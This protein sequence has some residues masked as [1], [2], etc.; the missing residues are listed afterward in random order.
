MSI[1]SLWQLDSNPFF[2]D[3]K[4]SGG[5]Y[6]NSYRDFIKRSKLDLSLKN[7]V[8][9][10]AFNFIPSYSSTVEIMF[11]SHIFNYE[12]LYTS[13]IHKKL[14]SID[15]TFNLSFDVRNDLDAESIK[16]YIE[17][18]AGEEPFPLQFAD[19]LGLDQQNAYKSLFSLPPYMVQ[20]FTCISVNHDESY[21]NQN[22][23]SMTFKNQDFSILNSKYILYAN[24]LPQRTKDIINEYTLKE[25]LDIE[26]SYPFS[27]IENNAVV[28]SDLFAPDSRLSYSRDGDKNRKLKVLELN[29]DKISTETLVKLLTF[30]IKRQGVET[31]KFKTKQGEVLNLVAGKIRHSYLYSGVHRVTV[32]CVEEVLSRKFHWKY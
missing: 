2:D 23:L 10:D 15:I 32:S 1:Q 18:K 7:F 12:N 25:E 8:L 30:F 28:Q 16:N 27:V 5:D 19:R 17:D 6:Y 24:C 20:W 29:F 14:N 9:D 31:F 21:N 13:V 26:P 3:S 4:N 22:N 11:P